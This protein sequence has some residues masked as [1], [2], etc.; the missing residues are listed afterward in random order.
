MTVFLSVVA[1]ALAVALLVVYRQLQDADFWRAHWRRRY[2]EL[3]AELSAA[4]S[5][6]QDFRANVEHALRV[7][8]RRFE[9]VTPADGAAV[10]VLR[11]AFPSLPTPPGPRV[12]E[13]SPSAGS[14]NSFALCP[15]CEDPSCVAPRQ[16]EDYFG[17]DAP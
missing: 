16:C 10:A 8:W 6:R 11:A 4:L 13:A 9:V 12:Q 15:W 5:E 14:S 17:A 2:G 3:D 7:L 1:L